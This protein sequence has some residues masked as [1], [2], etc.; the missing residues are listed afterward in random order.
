MH[1]VLI[2]LGSNMGDRIVH[3]KRAANFLLSLSTQAVRFSGVYESKPVGPGRFPYLIAMAQLTL[4]QAPLALLHL[5][6]NYEAENGRLPGSPRWTD[7][8]IDLDI[9]AYGDHIIHEQELHI[10]HPSFRDRLFVLQPLKELMPNWRDPVTLTS[11]D[12]LIDQAM[13]LRMVKT[14]SVLP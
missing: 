2:G 10:P 5:L 1:D 3:L 14:S 6:K 11:I 8:T 7:R 13:P 12:V 4:T 9:I